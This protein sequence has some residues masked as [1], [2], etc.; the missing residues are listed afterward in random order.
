[1][2]VGS[3]R[4]RFQ[5]N[6]KRKFVIFIVV[7]CLIG[8]GSAGAVY[9]VQHPDW[10]GGIASARSSASPS[11]APA[12]IENTIAPGVP[13]VSQ[14]PTAEPTPIALESF[15]AAASAAASVSATQVPE[16]SDE[17]NG[18][19]DG[20]AFLGNSSLEDMYVYGL[21]PDADFFYKVGLTVDKAFDT[22]AENG[23]VPIVE[24]IQGKNY[25]KIFL[26]F[27]NNELGWDSESRF[28]DEYER[29]IDAIR[30][31]DP[32][33]RLYVMGILP[34]TEEVSDKAQ[35]G[36]T[37]ERIDEYNEK[38]KVLANDNDCY[39]LD[40]GL[41]L[42]NDHGYLPS[43]AAADGVHLNKDYCVRWAEILR[44]E[45]GGEAG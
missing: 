39:F 25:D 3:K 28:F 14:V 5:K 20:V 44:N 32:G 2:R 8:A 19:S 38:L 34:V 15:E 18:P 41:A 40:L 1:M 7:L 36:V 13:A 10:L 21:I 24:E 31:E 4:L 27:G 29:L 37:Q 9:W 35:D 42:K 17:E 43:D 22:A 45:I 30:E 33:A 26:M 16:R 11:A 12:R 23:T 6:G